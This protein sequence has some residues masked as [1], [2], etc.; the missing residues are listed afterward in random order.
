[1]RFRFLSWSVFKLRTTL[2][3]KLNGAFVGTQCEDARA[4]K[5]RWMRLGREQADSNCCATRECK[6][7]NCSIVEVHADRRHRL[8]SIARAAIHSDLVCNEPRDANSEPAEHATERSHCIGS[9][10]Q[11]S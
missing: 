7:T 11:E 1:M 9:R 8:A 2:R 6:Q 5:L 10:P 4:G 3:L